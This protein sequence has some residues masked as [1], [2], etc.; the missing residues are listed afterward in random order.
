MHNGSTAIAMSGDDS[1][2]QQ[3]FVALSESI[4]K[5]QTC[6]SGHCT[7]RQRSPAQTY[8]LAPSFSAD[9]HSVACVADTRAR[10]YC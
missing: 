6:V 2:L 10:I 3:A 5:Q 4:V 1:S 7:A 8:P 9:L